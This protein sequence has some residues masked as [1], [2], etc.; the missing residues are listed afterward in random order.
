MPACM[1]SSLGSPSGTPSAGTPPDQQPMQVGLIVVVLHLGQQLQQHLLLHRIAVLK[2]A[3][4]PRCPHPYLI[5]EAEVHVC[6]P[7]AAAV[8]RHRRHQHLDRFSSSSTGLAEPING[9]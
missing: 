6:H 3:A 5:G 8:A 1:L 9:R 2:D 7:L 4:L